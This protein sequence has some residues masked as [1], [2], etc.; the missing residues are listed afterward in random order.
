VGAGRLAVR[1]AGELLLTLG[2]LVLLFVLWQLVWTDV[3]AAQAQRGTV[4]ALQQRWEPVPAAA[5]PSE[6]PPAGEPAPPRV[7]QDPATA[8]VAPEPRSGEAFAV[9]HVPRFGA[10]GVIGAAQGVGLGEVLNDGVLGHYPGTAMPG[11]VG[12]ASFAGHRTTYGRPLARIDE[13]QPG[14]PLVVEQ[15]EAWYV[16]RVTGASVVA[17]E[18]VEVIAPVPG[19]PGAEPTRRL[20]TLTACH[21]EYSARQRYVVHGELESWQPRS[22]GTP[23]ALT[24][25]PSAPVAG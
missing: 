19:E 17:P 22:A 10:D 16:Y 11:A 24:E 14:D 9:V 7:E 25:A 3:T 15:G 1:T 12:N 23:A 2:A 5:P 13:L 21:P 18:Q 20:I 8:P 6:E 4:Q